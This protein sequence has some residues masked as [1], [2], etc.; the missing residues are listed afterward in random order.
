MDCFV[1]QAPSC[2]VQETAMLTES[3][4]NML[5]TD[6]RP[7]SMVED[8]GFRS[9]IST[10]NPRYSMSYKRLEKKHRDIIEKW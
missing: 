7:L 5:V 3:V 10:F 2:T 4:L 1:H 6:M 9:M 8:K